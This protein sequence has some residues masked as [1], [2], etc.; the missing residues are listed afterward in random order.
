MGS[1]NDYE[2]LAATFRHEVGAFLRSTVSNL[3]K[4]ELNLTGYPPGNLETSSR[5]LWTTHS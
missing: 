4:D 2:I 5:H 3:P 1:L